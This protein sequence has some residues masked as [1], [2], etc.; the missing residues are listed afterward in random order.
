MI[1]AVKPGVHTI[2]IVEDLVYEWD[3]NLGRNINKSYTRTGVTKS[4]QFYDFEAEETQWINET[5]ARYTNS[6]MTD[7]EKATALWRVLRSAPFNQ[8]FYNIQLPDGTIDRMDK[9]T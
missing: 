2:E 9:I 6:G 5:V 8:Y 7:E 1:N 4:I 3:T